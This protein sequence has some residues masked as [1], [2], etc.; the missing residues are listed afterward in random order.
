LLENNNLKVID[1]HFNDINGGSFA[2]SA[3]RIDNKSFKINN[4]KIDKIIAKEIKYGLD[5]I[6][7]YLSFKKRVKKH[8]EDLIKLLISLK[9]SNKKVLGYGASTKGNVLLQYCNIN[10]EL[11][12]AIAEVNSDKYN[13]FTPG[14]KIPI[15]SENE[16]KAMNPDYFLV[17]PWHFKNY[18]L[19]K[20]KE[21]ISKGGKFI[22]PLPEIFIV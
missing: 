5:T 17:L 6:K 3:A 14:T 12:P 15:I 9:Q 1:V 16:A 19:E 2:V 8:K 20:E 11:L 21:F 18:I 7:P 10:T 22:F 13:C 4:K